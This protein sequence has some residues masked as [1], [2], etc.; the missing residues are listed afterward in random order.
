MN[1][2]SMVKEAY[3]RLKDAFTG[4]KNTYGPSGATPVVPKG[5]ITKTEKSVTVAPKKRGGMC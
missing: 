5:S 3:G 2:L 1:P 4:Q